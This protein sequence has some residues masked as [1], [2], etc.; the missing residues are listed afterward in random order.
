M[1]MT[2]R[3][4]TTASP[5]LWSDGS[6]FNGYI[7]SMIAPPL[8]ASSGGINWPGDGLLS[9]M[10]AES[11]SQTGQMRL[12]DVQVLPVYEGEISSNVGVFPANQLSPPGAKYYLYYYDIARRR[13]AG[14]A[15]AADFY[16][17]DA[18]GAITPP[19]LTV[20]T[21]PTSVPSPDS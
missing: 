15:S 5:V 2:I 7:V 18:S 10:S 12:P 3:K 14:P 11:W 16:T 21:A 9:F 4:L 8:T 19:T 1:P 20:P 6:K 13:I 17:F